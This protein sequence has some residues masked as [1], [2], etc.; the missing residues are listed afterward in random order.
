MFDQYGRLRP[1]GGETEA[2]G[3]R[4]SP[5]SDSGGPSKGSTEPESTVKSRSAIPS[6]LAL[7][8]C[9]RDG[10]QGCVCVCAS[11]WGVIATV[12]KPEGVGS[13]APYTPLDQ[14]VFD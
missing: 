7:R 11:V 2:P 5:H 9:S 3:V 1:S 13:G 14:P 12:V 10:G 6:I 8:I 4:L